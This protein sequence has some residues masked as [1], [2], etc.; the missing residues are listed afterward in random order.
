MLQ[1][2]NRYLWSV[3]GLTC[4]LV[5]GCGGGDGSARSEAPNL[6][7]A[8]LS[9]QSAGEELLQDFDTASASF[10]IAPT[11]KVASV[12]ITPTLQAPAGLTIQVFRPADDDEESAE[13]NVDIES[14]VVNLSTISSGD[15]VTMPLLDSDTV[16][17]VRITDSQDRSLSYTLSFAQQ[18]TDASLTEILYTRPVGFAISP[19]TFDSDTLEYDISVPYGTCSIGVLPRI[20]QRRSTATLN[21]EVVEHLETVNV[22]LTASFLSENENGEEV[23]NTVVNPVVIEVTAEDGETVKTYTSN[24]IREAGTEEDIAANANLNSLSFAVGSVSS[25]F[26]CAINAYTVSL[27]NREASTEF[28]AV[29]EVEGATMTIRDVELEDIEENRTSVMSGVP[30]TLA[31]DEGSTTFILTVTAADGETTETYSILVARLAINTVTVSTVEELHQAL[32][33]A[34]PRDAIEIQEGDYTGIATVE[35]SGSENAYFYA[36]A[37]GT[38]ENPIRVSSAA[39]ADVRLNG[40]DN[41]QHAVLLVTGDHW[42]FSNITLSDAETAAVVDG[43]TSNHFTSLSIENTQQG[44]AVRNGGEGNFLARTD[45][46]NVDQAIVVG[47]ADEV[48]ENNTFRQLTVGPNVSAQHVEL[49]SGAQN[50]LLEYNTFDTAGMGEEALEQSVIVSTGQASVLRFNTFHR[51]AAERLAKNELGQNIV[52]GE[53]LNQV[54][55][56]NSAE[57]GSQIY[58]NLFDLSGQAI[59]LVNSNNTA[60]VAVA[61]NF[62]VDVEDVRSDAQASDYIGAG[63]DTTFSVPSFMLR[64]VSADTCLERADILAESLTG[65]LVEID[66][67]VAFECDENNDAQRWRFVIGQDGY[68]QINDLS[69]TPQHLRT[70]PA[71]TLNS[72]ALTFHTDDGSATDDGLALRWRIIFD[73]NDAFI[74]NMIDNNFA[75]TVTTFPEAVTSHESGA[76]LFPLRGLENQRI[77]IEQVD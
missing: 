18:G 41:T 7:L 64:S 47:L 43:G 44:F 31:V 35:G 67:V 73:G 70:N 77:T 57:A 21:G 1:S 39:N 34:Q 69:S 30:F 26:V 65:G 3:L 51:E 71:P 22:P 42:R 76:L 56:I 52:D 11:T 10:T 5:A 61:E 8:S 45:I 16:I 48:N 13:W 72:Q 62:V 63:I 49:K 66:S 32:K 4:L 19:E 68:I 24:V 58:Q 17:V 46:T 9:V 74:L 14:F 6:S 40:S 27:D 12:D 15:T 29:T 54:I 2:V 38:E 53:N 37:S 50:T 75:I 28:T 23:L 55:S 60:S 59:P 36:S 25:D 20:S 33:N